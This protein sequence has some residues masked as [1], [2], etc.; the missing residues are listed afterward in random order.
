MP[1]E[2]LFIREDL[3]FFSFCLLPG[4]KMDAMVVIL[5]IL[6]NIK[7]SIPGLSFTEVGRALG[8]KWKKMSGIYSHCSF[9]H[10][11]FIY[12]NQEHAN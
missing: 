7:K 12:Y 1:M 4:V 9:I 10:L 3:F 6:Q 8:E 11:I 5:V 2:S